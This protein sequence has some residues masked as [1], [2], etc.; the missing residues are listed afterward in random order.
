M[1]QITGVVTA[2]HDGKAIRLILGMTGLAQ[3]QVEY[4]K[5]LGPLVAMFEDKSM[6]DFSV[7]LRATQVALERFHGDADPYLADD[8]LAQDLTIAVRVINLAFEGLQNAGPKSGK[9]K[10][11]PGNVERPRKARAAKRG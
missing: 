3:L 11:A 9:A 2:Q 10:A 4:G 6:P 7:L 8:L 5:D 1:S